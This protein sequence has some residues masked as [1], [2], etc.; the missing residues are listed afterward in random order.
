MIDTDTARTRVDRLLEP[1]LGE[2]D[3]R[4][5]RYAD[6][7]IVR[8]VIWQFH[9]FTPYELA[10]I[11]SPLL[12]RLRGIHQTSLAN[13]TYPCAL[14][15]RFEHSLGTAT[16]AARMLEAIELNAEPVA[17]QMKAET[18]LGALLH[19]IGHGPLSHSSEKFFEALVDGS[20]DPI[21]RGP[22]SLQGYDSIFSE[23]SAG[24]ILAYLVITSPSFGRL[25]KHIVEVYGDKYREIREIS[26]E[27]VGRMILGVDE[28]IGDDARFCREIVNGPF[29]AD[30]LDYLPRDGYYTGLRTGVDIERL[31]RTITT[32]SG[33]GAAK[34]IGV[35]LSG[36]SVLEQLIFSKTQL[37]ASLYHH[38][39]VRSAHQMVVSLLNLMAAN[40]YQPAGHDLLDPVSYLVLDDYDILHSHFGEPIISAAVQKIKSRQIPKRALVITWACFEE[41]DNVSLENFAKID[42]PTATQLAQEIEREA[43][44]ERG[45][46]FF[47]LPELPRL[48]G[49]AHAVVKV[50]KDRTLDLEDLFPAGAWAKAFQGYRRTAYV[51]TSSADR[52]K[53]GN[54]AKAVLAGMKR[55][56]HLNANA[57]ALAKL[58]SD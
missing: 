8:D 15:S 57:L 30:K 42:A 21:F 2:Y 38:H 33:K 4:M 43:G 36:A 54:A 50:S 5:R 26:L 24:E 12:Q 56:I 16:V 31:L 39:K 9:R 37:Y 44:L 27:R 13:F 17:P 6:S 23:S 22:D 46:V 25:W 35:I 29:D 40:S 14:H 53:V 55:K 7:K 47:D 41:N 3:K 52:R 1:L 19:D 45:A 49:T 10:I 18:R 32:V 34:Q 48:S 11:D 28:G 20:G 51:F 58:D